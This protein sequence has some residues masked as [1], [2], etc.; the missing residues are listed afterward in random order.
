MFFYYT[1]QRC[2]H[3]H[4]LAEHP[5]AHTHCI[6]IR[7]DS[8]SYHCVRIRGDSI[9]YAIKRYL[10][11]ALCAGFVLTISCLITQKGAVLSGTTLVIIVHY[12]HVLGER[13]SLRTYTCPF[14]YFCKKKETV[15]KVRGCLGIVL[16]RLEHVCSFLYQHPG[17]C[18]VAALVI[19]MWL[20]WRDSQ[21]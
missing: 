13:R 1:G 18:T 11:A 16:S 6:R 21:V 9:S 4:Y 3:W 10:W 7:S 20:S 12:S 14:C 17:M 15:G 19:L 8:I 2:A 5:L